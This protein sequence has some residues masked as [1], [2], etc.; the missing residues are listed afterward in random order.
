MLE[1]VIRTARSPDIPRLK[2]LVFILV[3]FLLK[4]NFGM[5]KR[6]IS[7]TLLNVV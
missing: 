2:M 1:H 4:L 7:T 3:S 5:K 6:R